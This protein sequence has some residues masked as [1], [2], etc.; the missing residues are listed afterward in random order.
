MD[1]AFVVDSSGSI[2]NDEPVETC[3]NWNALRGFIHAIIDDMIIGPN[4]VRVALIE[5]ESSAWIKWNL[6]T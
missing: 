3:A 6:T 2:C 4:D 1:L 5:F